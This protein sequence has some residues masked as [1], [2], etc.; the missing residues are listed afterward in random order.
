MTLNI[1]TN[2]EIPTKFTSGRH[3]INM[4]VTIPYSEADRLLKH[5]IACGKTNVYLN[6]LEE[7]KTTEPFSIYNKPFTL[8]IPKNELFKQH[9]TDTLKSDGYSMN[10]ISKVLNEPRIIRMVI[11]YRE[12]LIL[13][14]Y[15]DYE[16]VLTVE[17]VEALRKCIKSYETLDEK[18]RKPDHLIPD[19]KWN[20]MSVDEFTDPVTLQL[21]DNPYIASDGHTY[22]LFTLIKIFQGDR[23]SP[24]TREILEPIGKNNNSIGMHIFNF[25]EIGIPNIKVK[26]L[27]DKFIEG[28]L[29]VSQQKYFKYK[30]KYLNL[31]K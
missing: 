11:S 1:F 26:Q 12:N 21:L 2:Y 20:E 19:E 6:G 28:K 10:T 27:L 17:E 23:K 31:K 4:D 13:G 16:S 30:S 7:Y 9:I 5:I 8:P 22:S 3:W 15:T 14:I 24:L 18:V 25:K 29:K